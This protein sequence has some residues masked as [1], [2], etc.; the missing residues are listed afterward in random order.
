MP[1]TNKV[2][3]LGKD[4]AA[5]LLQAPSQLEAQAAGVNCCLS[6]LDMIESVP[7]FTCPVSLA[8]LCICPLL[9]SPGGQG[10]RPGSLLR[11][12]AHPCVCVVYVEQR[13]T[14]FPKQLSPDGTPLT[15][16]LES[17]TP[18]AC[19]TTALILG[20]QV[21][22]LQRPPGMEITSMRFRESTCFKRFSF[23]PAHVEDE[24]SFIRSPTNGC[25]WV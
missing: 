9:R 5:G 11:M 3:G 17:C 19:K 14:P 16:W 6:P 2:L 25:S 23:T 24:P 7:C 18:V 12:P 4:C 22:K 1:R 13:S 10:A 20:F 21:P 8:S 15:R